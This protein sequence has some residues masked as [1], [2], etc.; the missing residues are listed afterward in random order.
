MIARCMSRVSSLSSSTGS[1]YP[2][3]AIADSPL[4][5]PNLHPAPYP[6]P[7]IQI[8]LAEQP[9]EHL[10]LGTYEPVLQHEEKQR[11]RQESTERAQ[12]YSHPEQRRDHA[13]IH[14]IARHP[15]DAVGHQG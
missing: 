1:W 14:G 6:A 4:G 2:S 3:F 15:E 7:V 12:Q 9:L 8:V 11:H 5:S 10:L 13:Q